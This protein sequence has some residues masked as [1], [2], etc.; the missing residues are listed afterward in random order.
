MPASPSPCRSTS[1]PAITSAASTTFNQGSAGTF[2][3][4]STGN[5]TAALR[6]VRRRCLL[7]CRF[8]DNGNGTATLSGTP[9][10][11]TGG[12]YPITITASNGVSPA[13]SQSFTL[14]VD[15]PP[16]ITSSAST[17]FAELAHSNFTVTTTGNPT[18]ALSESGAL[19]SGVTFTDNG[20]GTASLAGTPD[21][22]TAG[23]YPIT[24]T[25]SN[26]FSPDASPIVHAERG[27][28]RVRARRSPRSTTPPS[29]WD[30]PDR[31]P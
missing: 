5:P 17:N 3:V 22:G 24:F 10:T 23:T 12:T 16:T 13:A 1:A 25:A 8:V 31:S 9:G 28:H 7:G 14:T 6:R 20:D 15:G 21:P 4:T 19:P 29:N 26:G 18:A 2:T 11:G 30:R 27:Q